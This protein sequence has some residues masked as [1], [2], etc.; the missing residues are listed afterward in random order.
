MEKY[1]LLF[2]MLNIILES[3]VQGAPM[4]EISFP[5]ST[6]LDNEYSNLTVTPETPTPALCK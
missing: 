3:F 5:N 1:F 6:S 4:S 2:L